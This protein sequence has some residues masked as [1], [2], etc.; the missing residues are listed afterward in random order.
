MPRG[1]YPRKLVS[2]VDRF[3]QKVD[4]CGMDECWSWTA[5]KTRDGYGK[6]SIGGYRR[7]W[8]LAHRLSWRLHCGPI[9]EGLFVLHHC[10]SPSCMNPRH[11]FL[12]TQA[13]NVRD[14]DMKGRRSYETGSRGEAN[15]SAKLARG[16]VLKIRNSSLPNRELAKLY[17]VTRSEIEHIKHRR[18]WA[19]L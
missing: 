8:I 6:I 4:V 14:M 1:V 7:S 19:W 11:L 17:S 13:D 10:D 12:G 3:W 16:E 5:A 15:G 2:L 9:P 18:A